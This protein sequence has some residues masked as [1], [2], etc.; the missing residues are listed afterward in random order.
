MTLALCFAVLDFSKSCVEN[1]G[2]PAISDV[3]DGDFVVDDSP[4]DPLA[5]LWPVDILDFH[6]TCT[7]LEYSRSNR[8]FRRRSL[9]SLALRQFHAALVVMIKLKV[10][11]EIDACIR[12]PDGTLTVHAAMIGFPQTVCT[13][14]RTWQS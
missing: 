8:L 5:T 1:A 10:V 4:L 3:F 9:D 11:T 13:C 12:K 2:S 7:P 6:C 14:S